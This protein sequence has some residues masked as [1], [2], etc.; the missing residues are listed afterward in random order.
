MLDKMGWFTA[1]IYVFFIYLKVVLICLYHR[2]SL[3]DIMF[4]MKTINQ[5]NCLT[6]WHSLNLLNSLLPGH[7]LE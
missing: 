6:E 4:A 2:V 5:L 3:P 7:R 1:C